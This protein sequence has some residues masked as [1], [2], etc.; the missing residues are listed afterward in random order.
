MPRLHWFKKQMEKLL[1]DHGLVGRDGLMVIEGYAMMAKG[2][3]FNIG[4][5][6]GV[7]KLVAWEYDVDILVVPP[8]T[9]KKF[10]TGKGNAN[11]EAMLKAVHNKWGYLTFFNDE[12]DAYALYRFGEATQSRKWKRSSDGLTFM[13]KCEYISSDNS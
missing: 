13:G 10:C 9:L 8:T 12:A 3:V 5:L 11:K 6:G 2:R 1:I 4:E 7:L